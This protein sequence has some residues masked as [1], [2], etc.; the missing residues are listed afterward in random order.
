[1]N[2]FVVP[3]GN[4]FTVQTDKGTVIYNI[5]KK[6]LSGNKFTLYDMNNYSL[7]SL[8]TVEGGKKPAYNI[9][10]NDEI[11][12]ELKCLSIFLDPSFEC[13]GKNMKFEL[14]SQNRKNFVMFRD[15]NKVGGINTVVM[16]T[17]ELQYEIIID[18]KAFDDYIP[19]FA[20]ALDKAFGD[21]NKGK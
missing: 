21:I 18:N 5:K 16:T 15:G 20:V 13:M 4:R 3:K 9:I 11:F 19:L 8:V 2:L 1:M 10:L 17:G 14:K 12:M 7:Y 6:G